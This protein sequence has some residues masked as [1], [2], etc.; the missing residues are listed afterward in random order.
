[1]KL[2][3]AINGAR[4][5]GAHPN[6]PTSVE[7]LGRE[8]EESVEAGAD[9]IHLHVR[10]SSGA[11]SLRAEAVAACVGAVRLRVSV[12]I[13][14][15]TGAW[16]VPD[17]A[18][19]E[20]LIAAWNVLPDYASVNFHENGA[21]DLA[22]LL[23]RL[24]IGIEGGVSNDRAA[25]VLVQSGMGPLCRHLLVEPMEQDL[26]SALLTLARLEARINEAGIAVP[27]ILHGM[28]APT[29]ALLDEAVRRGYAVRMG[30]EDTL[31]T[32]DGRLAANN[33]E[34]VRLAASRARLLSQ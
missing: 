14:V 34:L 9:T 18:E 13:G 2:Q 25:D 3:A 21:V 27:R 19:R 8:A 11:E 1:M 7:A 32:P 20:R 17:V 29:W 4:P 28:G 26:D 30:L 12:P 33:A 31:H 22:H 6:L 23:L 10:D 5:V 15:S 16:I 24:G